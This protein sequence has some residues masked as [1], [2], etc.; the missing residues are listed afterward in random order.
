M[1]IKRYSK[2]K[3]LFAGVGVEM[4]LTIVQVAISCCPPPTFPT[5][6]PLGACINLSFRIQFFMQRFSM[7]PS[8]SAIERM[9]AFTILALNFS[10]SV[11]VLPFSLCYREEDCI[12]FFMQ[13]FSIALQPLL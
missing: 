6:S 2:I 7:G 4:L 10:C 9:I 5:C 11:L 13:C 1:I 8:A 12:Q 3:E